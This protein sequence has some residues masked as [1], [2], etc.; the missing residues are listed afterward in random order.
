MFICKS[1]GLN[2]LSRFQDGGH[3][4]P[5][6]L[7]RAL[8][9]HPSYGHLPMNPNLVERNTSPRPSPHFAPPTPQNAEREKR[10][11]RFGKLATPD[12]SRFRGSMREFF[13]GNLLPEGEGQDEGG[14]SIQRPSREPLFE[15]P[16]PWF[17]P[18][19]TSRKQLQRISGARHKRRFFPPGK[20]ARL[21][22]KQG[23]LPPRQKKRPTYG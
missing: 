7:P 8:P 23:C 21:Y 13:R 19:I 18:L 1:F 11:P 6:D 5:L 14:G 4:V 22:G 12:S 15:K 2:W 16:L 17:Y 10:L 3:S 9:P 20:D